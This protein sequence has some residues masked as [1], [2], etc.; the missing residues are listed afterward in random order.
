M[1]EQFSNKGD[2]KH[3]HFFHFIIFPF[4]VGAVPVV[5]VVDT[6][7]GVKVDRVHVVHV[8][9]RGG[10]QDSNKQETDNWWLSHGS[11]AHKTDRM[12]V[13]W[14]PVPQAHPTTAHY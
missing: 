11:R 4:T 7:T 8:H 13:T 3:L 6:G 12:V 2:V 5:D 14:S 10:V 1:K 9:S